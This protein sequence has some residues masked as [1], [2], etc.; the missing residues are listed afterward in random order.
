MARRSKA[1]FEKRARE[2]K[3]AEKAAEKREARAQRGD[4]ARPGTPAV[5]TSDDLAGYG[6]A[7][8]EA[9]DEP[10]ADDDSQAS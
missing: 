2:K 5:A 7:S 3:K 10:D 9:S 4:D 1:S 8:D 6:L